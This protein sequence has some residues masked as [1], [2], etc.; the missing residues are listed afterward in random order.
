MSHSGGWVPG[1][2]TRWGRNV[3]VKGVPV[4][5]SVVPSTMTLPC[6]A[7]PEVM[8][9]ADT[10]TDTGWL[11]G[12]GWGAT[13]IVSRLTSGPSGTP[14]SAPSGTARTSPHV[15][16]SADSTAGEVTHRLVPFSI[17]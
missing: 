12:T 2:W 11:S 16:P 15:L 13:E 3:W 1:I 14:R 10:V 9:V 8:S 4:V 6:T 7:A 17:R 5:P